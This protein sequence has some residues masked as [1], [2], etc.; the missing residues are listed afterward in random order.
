MQPKRPGPCKARER[1]ERTA[2][3]RERNKRDEQ[4]KEVLG[5]KKKKRKTKK[6]SMDGPTLA[7]S[8]RLI[9][10]RGPLLSQL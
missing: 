3:E 10:S 7:N 4:K 5:E 6:K 8:L 1:D 9:G 2:A